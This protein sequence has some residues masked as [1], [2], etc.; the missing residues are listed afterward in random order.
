MHWPEFTVHLPS[1]VLF[2]DMLEIAFSSPQQLVAHL[3]AALGITLVAASAMVRTMLP[4]RWLAVGSN[5]ALIAYGALHPAMITMLIA[6]ALLPVNIFRVIEITRLTRRV[7]RANVAADMAELWLR[8]HM[9]ARHLKAGHVLF[10]RGDI[11]QHLYLLAEGEMELVEISHTLEIGRIF[12][13]IAIFSSNH[14]RTHSV[15]CVTKCTVLEI[16]ESTVRQ[17]YYQNPAFGFHL[18]G[19]LA[20]RLGADVERQRNEQLAEAVQSA[21]R[22][23]DAL[24]EPAPKA[25]RS[26]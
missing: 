5:L 8:P 14:M 12:G 2:L 22:H 13:E 18:I 9:K 7:Q 6:F 19:L 17:L 21:A 26:A 24:D 11:A 10:N 23:S 15:R 4:L 3:A 25:A 1:W 20:S 16:H